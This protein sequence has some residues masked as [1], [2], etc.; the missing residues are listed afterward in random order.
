MSLAPNNDFLIV[1]KLI[2][3]NYFKL[4]DLLI[5]K[6][7]IEY[8]A[9]SFKING[10][11]IIS[12]SSKITPKKI[13]QFVTLWKRINNGPIEPFNSSDK[14]NLFIVNTRYKNN[15]GQFVFPKSVLIKQG[16]ITNNTKEGKRAI[17]VYPPWDKPT[18]K[19]AIKTQLWQLN[20]F[21][22]ININSPIDIDN[23]KRLYSL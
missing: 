9:C 6:E 1:K 17:R 20:Y 13:G 10:Q 7:S 3:D 22:P 15:F 21:L 8:A 16:I 5:D 23:V 4:S 2:Y 14:L 18:S 19:Q 12:R 11:Y